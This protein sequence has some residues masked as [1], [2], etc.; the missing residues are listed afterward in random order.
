M[1]YSR[2]IKIWIPEI[3]DVDDFSIFVLVSAAG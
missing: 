2:D 3:L 1:F